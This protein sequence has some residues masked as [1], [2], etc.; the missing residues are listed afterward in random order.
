MKSKYDVPFIGKKIKLMVNK[1]D[2]KFVTNTDFKV[3]LVNEYLLSMGAAMLFKG[4]DNKS[5]HEYTYA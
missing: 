1:T 5:Y 3:F 4:V 2:A